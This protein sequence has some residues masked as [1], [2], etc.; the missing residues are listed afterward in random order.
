MREKKTE[1]KYIAQLFLRRGF[2]NATPVVNES[3]LT[4]KSY[5]SEILECL[6]SSTGEPVYRRSGTKNLPFAT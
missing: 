5:L 6:S 3:K 2:V 4:H 1:C